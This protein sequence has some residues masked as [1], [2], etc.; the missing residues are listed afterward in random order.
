[1]PLAQQF[2]H[3]CRTRSRRCSPSRLNCQHQNCRHCLLQARSP[4]QFLRGLRCLAREPCRPTRR[5]RLWAWPPI[6]HRPRPDVN[7]FS[8]ETLKV[9]THTKVKKYCKFQIC[10]FLVTNSKC[11]KYE[12]C[13][14]WYKRHC[15]LKL[16]GTIIGVILHKLFNGVYAKTRWHGWA[17]YQHEI[18]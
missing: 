6:F 17:I 3:L 1:M 7:R 2:S 12:A 13:Y 9:K 4:R 14:T 5:G 18:S 8:A 16:I 15:R 10:L 11:M